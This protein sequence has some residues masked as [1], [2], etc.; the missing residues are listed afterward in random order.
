MNGHVYVGNH[1]DGLMQGEGRYTW[2]NGTVYAGTF[3]AGKVMGGGWG[4]WLLCL[5]ST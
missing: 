5:Y 4:L 3:T 2:A 1:E